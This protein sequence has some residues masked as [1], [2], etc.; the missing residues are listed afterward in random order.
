MLFEWE[1]RIIAAVWDDWK[2]LLILFFIIYCFLQIYKWMIQKSV[3]APPHLFFTF[4]SC[5]ENFLDYE[6]VFSSSVSAFQQKLMKTHQLSLKSHFL[7]TMIICCWPYHITSAL[8]EKKKNP[9]ELMKKPPFKIPANCMLWINY[10]CNP[11][12][13]WGDHKVLLTS[14]TNTNILYARKRWIPV[15]WR[16]L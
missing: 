11:G 10:I 4:E 3:M 7:F 2:C 12:H 9:I 15:G 1:K 14:I 6:S 16:W 5:V 13:G 8:S